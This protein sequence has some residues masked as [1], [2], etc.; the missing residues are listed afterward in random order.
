MPTD[1]AALWRELA[2]SDLMASAEGEAQMVER[3]RRVARQLDSGEKREADPLLE[4]I[5]G[6]L[7]PEMSVLDIGAGIG[8]WTLPMAEKAR[9]V[10]AVEPLPGMRQVL[11][12]RVS[13]R[14]LTSVT[15][16][17]APWMEAEVSPH[18]VA[19]AAHAT[20]TTAD[21]V[22]FV[23]KMDA[24]ARRTCYLAFRLP[25]HDGV[26]GELSLRIRGRWHDSP[27][28]IVGYNLLLTAGFYP[29]VLMEPRPTR[30]WTDPT[31]DAAL[32]RAKRHLH[33]T[34]A[35]HDATIRQ[36]LSRRLTLADGACRW[37]DGMRSALLWWDNA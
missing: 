2:S 28:F 24:C 35:S 7:E 1:W 9:R 17:D 12:E 4:F 25:A 34:D 21:L 29:N 6:R 11:L 36:V 8:R 23:R 20:Y 19:V 13:S 3:W 16:A 30:Y 14:G 32:A 27:N 26:I 15:A 33:L 18:D 10:T 5:L 31:L 37:P 22:G